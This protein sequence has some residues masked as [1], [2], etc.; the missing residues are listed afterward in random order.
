MSSMLGS[1]TSSNFLKKGTIGSLVNRRL[2]VVE[3][4]LYGSQTSAS[5]SFRQYN[6]EEVYT[7]LNFLRACLLSTFKSDFF[8][9]R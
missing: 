7:C 9:M 5:T 2:L 1:Q 8:C 6:E 4:L 3:A